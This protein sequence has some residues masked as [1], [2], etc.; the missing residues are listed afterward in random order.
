[1]F[2]RCAWGIFVCHA[3][4]SVLLPCEDES[5]VVITPG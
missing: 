5:L 1:M 2:G 4:L 3:G